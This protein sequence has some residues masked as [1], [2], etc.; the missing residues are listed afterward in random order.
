M[1]TMQQ[2]R[3]LDISYQETDTF[4]CSSKIYILDRSSFNLLNVYWRPYL[5]CP[6]TIG[7]KYHT[8]YPLIPCPL[9]ISILPQFSFTFS[10]NFCLILRRCETPAVLLT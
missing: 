2:L 8:K 6:L 10:Y 9:V 7:S 1:P 5:L 4:K 3:A